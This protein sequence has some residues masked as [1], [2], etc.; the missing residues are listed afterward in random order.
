MSELINKELISHLQ[1]SCIG[2]FTAQCQIG[3]GEIYLVSQV[4]LSRPPLIKKDDVSV[5]DSDY[6]LTFKGNF[7]KTVILKKGSYDCSIELQRIKNS[8]GDLE[9]IYLIV[10]DE[11]Q[12]GSIF[13]TSIDKEFYLKNSMYANLVDCEYNRCSHIAQN[14]A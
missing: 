6:K 12:K 9:N 4:V 8:V 1:K 10:H 13:V 7:S 2:S 14:R 5:V 3:E 11:S